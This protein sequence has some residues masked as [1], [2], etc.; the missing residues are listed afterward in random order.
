MV[1]K[2]KTIKKYKLRR[3]STK[4]YKKSVKKYRKNAKPR[5]SMKKNTKK[6]VKR[7]T[8]RYKLQF[9]GGGCP[10]KNII[11]LLGLKWNGKDINQLMGT[12]K[13]ATGQQGSDPTNSVKIYLNPKDGGISHSKKKEY[14]ENISYMIIIFMYFYIEKCSNPQNKKILMDEFGTYNTVKDSKPVFKSID[15][16]EQDELD[17][18]SFEDNFKEIMKDF[19]SCQL[20]KNN[21]L[22]DKIIIQFLEKY[23][24]DR[25]GRD[26][27]QKLNDELMELYTKYKLPEPGDATN[28]FRK[29]II[30]L[31]KRSFTH[32][33]DMITDL[34]KLYIQYESSDSG[35]NNIETI[36]VNEFENYLTIINSILYIQHIVSFLLKSMD[37][38]IQISDTSDKLHE[39]YLVSKIIS[40]I[41]SESSS[42][43]LLYQVLFET[44][45][46]VG[47]PSSKFYGS[48]TL[49]G[50]YAKNS[51]LFDP[52]GN[53][54]NLSES[55]LEKYYGYLCN[56]RVALFLYSNIF[57]LIQPN[58]NKNLS[59]PIT[60]QCKTENT[61]QAGQS[62]LKLADVYES[63]NVSQDNGKISV[64]TD[65]FDESCGG[66]MI[67]ER[68]NDEEIVDKTKILFSSLKNIQEM[69][70]KNKDKYNYPLL[71]MFLAL[72]VKEDTEIVA[73]NILLGDSKTVYEYIE[74]VKEHLMLDG[75][76]RSKFVPLSVDFTPSKK[77]LGTSVTMT[78]GHYSNY[79][80]KCAPTSI[81]INHLLQYKFSDSSNN[82]SST[83]AEINSKEEDDNPVDGFNNYLKADEISQYFYEYIL[84]IVYLFMLLMDE[85]QELYG[86][87]YIF[88]LKES[89]IYSVC[90]DIISKYPTQVLNFKDLKLYD[91][92]LIYELFNR[93]IDLSEYLMVIHIYLNY[94]MTNDKGFKQQSF[95]DLDSTSSRLDIS[96]GA[97]K[98]L[99]DTK[100]INVIYNYKSTPGN[101][102]KIYGMYSELL[103]S[104]KSING[105]T[106]QESFVQQVKEFP[107]LLKKIGGD[108]SSEYK[109]KKYPVDGDSLFKDVMKYLRVEG[110]Q[111]LGGEGNALGKLI[112]ES[113][114]LEKFYTALKGEY[115]LT[116]TDEDYTDKLRESVEKSEAGMGV[117]TSV[118]PIVSSKS[119]TTEGKAV[120]G[121]TTPDSP[122]V[123]VPQQQ[124]Q[125]QQF[126]QGVPLYGSE[127]HPHSGYM[128]PRYFHGYQ[129]GQ[130]PSS[131]IPGGQYPSSQI[132]G[133]QYPSSQIPGGQYP[134]SQIP[135]GQY[136]S[137]QIPE[138]QYPFKD[139]MAVSPELQ[140]SYMY[141]KDKY[142]PEEIGAV[143]VDLDDYND[144]YYNYLMNVVLCVNIDDPQIK[145]NIF[146][147][148]TQ[149]KTYPQYYY[150]QF[151]S[152]G[153]P[154]EAA[155]EFKLA[156]RP[157]GPL[158]EL[159]DG[160]KMKKYYTELNLAPKGSEEY[161]MALRNPNNK[162]PTVTYTGNV[163]QQL[164]HKMVVDFID[165]YMDEL[166]NNIQ[167]WFFSVKYSGE[168]KTGVDLLVIKDK[169]LEEFINDLTRAGFDST[170]SDISDLFKSL[171][172]IYRGLGTSGEAGEDGDTRPDGQL[173]LFIDYFE[174]VN[175]LEEYTNALNIIRENV[176]KLVDKLHRS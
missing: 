52:D 66:K 84:Q 107:G 146:F 129:G 151:N 5:K 155:Y 31:R 94:L 99:I 133:G 81:L 106:F 11:S 118:K 112:S 159:F 156:D 92:L 152:R 41:I 12:L 86:K 173:K 135:E 26:I 33:N 119:L 157:S 136:P 43:E 50:F 105:K 63:I 64:K 97:N 104:E 6:Q 32:K 72:K 22:E 25:T 28:I 140:S 2:K 103:Q 17:F 139:S 166:Y 38:D 127:T 77:E 54:Y 158:V 142:L 165:N 113:E 145:Y 34:K 13:T 73:D 82:L 75:R 35:T 16:R 161:I 21:K 175:L 70:Q 29:I 45:F 176:I 62:Q 154:S 143:I 51:Y 56:I 147:V 108:E 65:Y 87:N 122:Q 111:S 42:S 39:F 76:E 132:P 126:Q 36:E 124:I 131:Q 9:G 114:N 79:I 8:K 4:K 164:L 149:D 74:Y 167:D 58:L 168:T 162:R 57:Q 171:C 30:A 101:N 120:G 60:I 80:Q 130:Y 137:S 153:S 85:K 100:L 47:S 23:A 49:I 1:V 174:I 170:K 24:L 96:R 141:R 68:S 144:V 67:K 148:P 128:D 102:K 88:T 90:Y 116:E 169:L 110:F 48:Q 83:L 109:T 123:V 37:I 89:G 44:C 19:Y 78:Y 40:S 15:Q 20:R 93:I 150:S 98:G 115:T 10:T 69:F 134:S 121:E 55:D 163:K 18:R 46:K 7:D 27:K 117:S 138:G 95:L 61:S 53:N 91:V 125:Q 59:I 14:I 3:K 172:I 160:D 71:S